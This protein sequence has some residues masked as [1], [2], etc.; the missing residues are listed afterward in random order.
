VNKKVDLHH[1]NGSITSLLDEI[2]DQ[3]KKFLIHSHFNREQRAYINSLRS[4]SSDTSYVAVQMDF[5]ENYTLIRQREVQAAHWNNIQATLFTIH[6]KAG[7]NHKNMVVISD[8]MRHDTAFVY[9]AQQLIVEFVK[10]HYPQVT[11]INYI[12][13]SEHNNL[14][15]TFFVILVMELEVI[16]RTIQT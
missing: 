14:H 10:K 5:A 16:L 1:I 4:Q 9:C 8:Y 2:D 15:K 7:T 13:Y 3:W 6:I 12:R 11:K